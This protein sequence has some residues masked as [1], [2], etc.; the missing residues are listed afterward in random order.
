MPP[1]VSR[2]VYAGRSTTLGGN[3]GS[4]AT[5]PFYA[6]MSAL[7]LPPTKWA[8]P[9]RDTDGGA[10]TRSAAEEAACCMATL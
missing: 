2:R 6:M 4:H 5:A 9:P 10:L 1:P 7:L 3:R 8:S